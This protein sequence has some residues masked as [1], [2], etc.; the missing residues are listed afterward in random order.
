MFDL[1]SLKTLAA[2]G[3]LAVAAGGANAAT[4]TLAGEGGIYDLVTSPTLSVTEK[5]LPGNSTIE[6]TITCASC[7]GFVWDA[8]MAVLDTIEPY[9]ASAFDYDPASEARI[10]EVFSALLGLTGSDV[11]TSADV[12][13]IDLLASDNGSNFTFN[14]TTDYFFVKYGQFTSFFYTG[15]TAQ[16]VTFAGKPGLSNYGGIAPIPVPAAGFLLLGAL[17]GLAM[18]RRRRK[19]A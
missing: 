7:V 12:T 1:K 16:D 8:T 17:G 3:A 15:G 6:A 2:A 14:V 18:V 11:L 5:T 9:F 19:A 13:K 10:A 4:V